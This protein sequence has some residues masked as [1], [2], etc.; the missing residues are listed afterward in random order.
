MTACIV[1]GCQLRR[2]EA[3]ALCGGA[4]LKQT[5]LPSN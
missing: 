3:M 2:G 1:F 4:D 5:R